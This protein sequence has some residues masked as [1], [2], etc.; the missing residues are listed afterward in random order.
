MDGTSSPPV[1]EMAMRMASARALKAASALR[2]SVYNAQDIL[3]D[4]MS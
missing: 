1:R 2:V 4:E 3:M